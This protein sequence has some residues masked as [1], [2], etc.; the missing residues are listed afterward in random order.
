MKSAS[1]KRNQAIPSIC[2]AAGW[3]LRLFSLGVLMMPVASAQQQDEQQGVDQGNYNIKQS[4]EF[5]GRFTSIT[6]DQQTYDTM[7]NLQQGPRLLN[8]T[9]EMR[10][11]DHHGTFFDRFYFSNFGYGGDPNVVSVVRLSKNKWYSFDGMFRHDENFW[12]Y[13]ILAN[14]FNPAPLQSNAP[15]GIFNPVANAQP[16]TS[17]T[18]KSSPCRRTTSTPEGTCKTTG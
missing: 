13:S 9:M 6:G 12:D 8:F 16:S 5:G 3:F 14:P 7:V 10:S 2:V 4:I 18:R 15:S 11:L 1:C 17:S